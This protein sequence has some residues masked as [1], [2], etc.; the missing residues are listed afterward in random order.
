[1]LLEVT[2][3]FLKPDEHEIQPIVNVGRNVSAAFAAAAVLCLALTGYLEAGLLGMIATGI[4][5]GLCSDLL[6]HAHYMK[7]DAGLALGVAML[8]LA[9]RMI[10][11]RWR[12][13]WAELLAVAF[14]GLACG[15]ASSA[16]YVGAFSI[17]IALLILFAGH[18]WR[19]TDLLLRP[20][21]LIAFLALTLWAINYR[22]LQ[23]WEKFKEVVDNESV[24]ATTGHQGQTM[25]IPQG[26]YLGVIY[27][28]TPLPV[29]ILAVAGV[30]VLGVFFRQT[31][32]WQ[33]FIVVMT[34]AIVAM[35]CYCRL[36]FP[37]YAL[38][39]VVLLHLLAGL[40]IAWAWMWLGDLSRVR[41]AIVIAATIAIA[42]CA[43]SC[44]D[45]L[46][47]FADDSRDRM[48]QWL[49]DHTA[50][51]DRVVVD[52]Y[53]GLFRGTSGSQRM[54]IKDGVDVDGYFFAV[55]RGDPDEL[56]SEGYKFVVVC[57]LAYI[58]LFDGYRLT[59][60]GYEDRYDTPRQNYEKLFKQAQ[61]VWVAKPRRNLM[62]YTN[63]EIR[64][65][66]LK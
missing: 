17:P 12:H 27:K 20:L 8:V 38:P 39:V 40:T 23:D 11:H 58:R 22:A 4:L 3:R 18:R 19:W 29:L 15:V 2:H 59:M 51:G 5:C 26:Y 10:W 55:E 61:L 32:G 53:A 64:I 63:P 14:L 1:L 60:E 25:A 30:V 7:E 66:Q 33:W 6:V 46:R 41:S 50:S 21:V 24:H 65:Y 28:M 42:V 57:E 52:N 36:A 48:R 43:W 54:E 62:A 13:W 56:K 44:F 49:L 37:R 31:H 45:D 47:Q 35:L 9:T 34:A 16:K